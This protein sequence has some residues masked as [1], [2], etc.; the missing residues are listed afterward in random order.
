MGERGEAN[1]LI[2]GSM[3]ERD[4]SCYYRE[5]TVKINLSIQQC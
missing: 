4:I 1:N 2:E 3:D 5:Y